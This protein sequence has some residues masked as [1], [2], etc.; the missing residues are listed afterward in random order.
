[1]KETYIRPITV[2]FTALLLMVMLF[3]IFAAYVIAA[4]EENYIPV[5][6]VLVVKESSGK[7][8]SQ[9]GHLNIFDQETEGETIIKPFC[10]GSYTFTIENKVNQPFRYELTITDENLAQIPMEFR[11]KGSNGNY[12]VGSSSQWVGIEDLSD[13]AGLDERWT[14]ASY[15]IDWR[16]KGDQDAIDTDAGIYAQNGAVYTLNFIVQIETDVPTQVDIDFTLAAI[17]TLIFSLVIVAVLLLLVFCAF[18]KKNV[19]VSR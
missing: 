13:I 2:T 5:D 14:S 8:W 3:G 18:S 17:M 1:M 12:I 16:W 15:T 7:Q 11:L 19:E 4:T 6:N 10:F 9:L